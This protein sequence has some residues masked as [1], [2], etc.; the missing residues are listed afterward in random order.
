MYRAGTPEISDEEYDS[1]VEQLR[2]LNPNNT[3]LNKVE[4]EDFKGKKVYKHSRP[5]LSID[6]AYTVKDM[7]KYLKRINKAMK[8]L[9]LDKQKEDVMFVLTPK[10]DGIA[11]EFDKGRLLSRG[12]GI[13]GFDITDLFTKGVVN[14]AE[15]K[16]IT[17]YGEIV[18]EKE[19]FDSNLKDLFEH[20]RN[21]IAGVINT[22][23][24]N[25]HQAL[26]DRKIKFVPYG[27]L[28]SL[29][30]PHVE[31]KPEIILEAQT[32]LSKFNC[33]YPTDGMYLD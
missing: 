19:Y 18:I 3:F 20:P 28:P 30:I 25:L 33:I 29:G 7:E 11:G 24:P 21:I 22:V 4:V 2:L 32:L 14:G 16:Y 1:L 26:R 15:F 6:K 5:M 10:V 8:D 12:D 13:E 23:N 27:D 9:G 17:C 31:F